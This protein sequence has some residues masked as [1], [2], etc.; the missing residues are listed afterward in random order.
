MAV[1]SRN[2]K[3][4][5]T[6]FSGKEITNIASESEVKGDFKIAGNLQV[7]GKVS[8]KIYCNS[9]VVLSKTS[10]CDG[11]I[12]ARKITVQGKY[13]GHLEADYIELID[14]CVV[15]GEIISNRILMKEGV[16][17]EGTSKHREAFL[18]DKNIILEIEK[19]K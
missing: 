14:N 4:T 5:D 16:I 13:T 1:F 6:N 2:D 11:S 12:I 19:K 8:G 9:E 3:A 18:P 10:V 7:D 15:S 17:F